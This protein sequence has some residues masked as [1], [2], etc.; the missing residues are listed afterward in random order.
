M[1]I[2]ESKGYI[3]YQYPYKIAFISDTHLGSQTEDLY[4]INKAFDIIDKNNVKLIFHLGDLI[5]GTE[6]YSVDGLKVVGAKEQGDYVIFNYP[7]ISGLKTYCIRAGHDDSFIYQGGMD[8]LKYITD[9]RND[10]YILPN[11]YFYVQTNTINLKLKHHIANELNK[12]IDIAIQGH[13]HMF[14]YYELENNILI[15]LPALTGNVHDKKD[16]G[17]VIATFYENF[18]EFKKYSIYDNTNNIA[19]QYVK[20]VR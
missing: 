14:N 7:L 17:F 13:Y 9:N 12:D 3:N 2:N 10:F 4:A 16:I 8:V 11:N 5:D 15:V 20:K 18:I 6:E 19:K 1:F